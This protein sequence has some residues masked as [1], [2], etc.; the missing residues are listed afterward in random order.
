MKNNKKIEKLDF[1]KFMSG[2]L[3]IEDFY[4]K[5]TVRRIRRSKCN[6]KKLAKFMDVKTQKET[7]ALMKK[8]G[9]PFTEYNSWY[10]V[11]D[12][13]CDGFDELVKNHLGNNVHWKK[14]SETY[15]KMSNCRCFGML[16]TLRW[17]K[18]GNRYHTPQFKSLADCQRWCDRHGIVVD[19]KKAYE[20]SKKI[21]MKE[22][23]DNK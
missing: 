23:K 16:R 8:I 11:L 19:V 1:K 15:K 9:S 18:L 14:R 6:E 4:L 22:R 7:N 17:M 12:C 20:E 3:D 21:D 13:V 5:Y 10:Y 2:D